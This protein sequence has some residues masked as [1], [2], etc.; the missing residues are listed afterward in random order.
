MQLRSKKALYENWYVDSNHFSFGKNWQHFL[1]TLNKERVK[2]AEK[3][4]ITFLGGK[5]NIADKSF[6]DIGCGSGLFSL[7]AYRLGAKKIMSIDIDD[8]SLVCTTLLRKRQKNPAN[9][10]IHKGSALDGEFLQSL[11]TFDILYSWGVLHH[12]GDMY[13]ALENIMSLST[14]KGKMFIAL[15]NDNNI[16]LE[17]T[18]S[19]WIKVKRIYN[20]SDW[21]AKKFIEI[22]YIVYYII[23][24]I[25]SGRN[26]YL[27]IY[28]YQSLRGMNFMTDIRDWLGGY[29][30][31][32]AKPEQITHFFAEHGY[33]CIKFN[34]ARSI[35]C[36][37]FL[38]VRKE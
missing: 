20:Q 10:K 28:G 22:I 35:G 1:K 9:W 18:S 8:F 3:S 6:V 15:Y 12:T 30:Y 17:G 13:A 27:Y 37:E 34:Q 31:E 7:A 4:L 32:Y 23:G 38:F 36:N 16:I 19:F 5:E 29:P 21:L 26:P 11:G 33:E 24:L 14:S 2:E 25:V